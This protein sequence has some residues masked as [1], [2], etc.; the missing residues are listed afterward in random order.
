MQSH[1]FDSSG[2]AVA[3]KAEDYNITGLVNSGM[4]W[5]SGAIPNWATDG[6]D[7]NSVQ[8]LQAALLPR[9]DTRNEPLASQ[10]RTFRTLNEFFSDSGVVMTIIIEATSRSFNYLLTEIAPV[11]KWAGGNQIKIKKLVFHDSI[12]DTV[13]ELGIGD[14][15]TQSYHERTQNTMRIGKAVQMA[16]QTLETEAGRV[17]FMMQ[18]AQV[19]N[20]VNNRAQLEVLINTLAPPVD[21]S[22]WLRCWNAPLD[23]R[24]FKRF[25]DFEHELFGI[26]NRSAEPLLKIDTYAKKISSQNRTNFDTFIV[27]VGFDSWLQWHS[28]WETSYAYT[29]KTSAPDRLRDTPQKFVEDALSRR[30]MKVFPSRHFDLAKGTERIPWDPYIHETVQGDYIPLSIHRCIESSYR[31]RIIPPPD[32][33]SPDSGSSSS[34]GLLLKPHYPSTTVKTSQVDYG[35]LTENELQES[36]EKYIKFS[37]FRE[38]MKRVGPAIEKKP[39]MITR[40][41]KNP[42]R[43]FDRRL[44]SVYTQNHH[45][46]VPCP[47]EYNKALAACGLFAKNANGEYILTPELG[48]SFFSAWASPLDYLQQQEFYNLYQFVEEIE[49]FLDKYFERDNETSSRG[50]DLSNSNMLS[51]S[52][53]PQYPITATTAAN[54][55]RRGVRYTQG[56]LAS[57]GT[58]DT[59]EI[60]R[61]TNDQVSELKERYPHLMHNQLVIDALPLA[62]AYYTIQKAAA[63]VVA[64]VNDANF[65]PSSVNW[66][67][68]ALFSYFD[69][70]L[71]PMSGRQQQLDTV[72]DD[73]GDGDD[74]MNQIFGT[75]VRPSNA[76]SSSPGEEKERERK[77]QQQPNEMDP[78][79]TTE[80]NDIKNCLLSITTAPHFIVPVFIQD[81]KFQKW[82]EEK[83]IPRGLTVKEMR[84]ELKKVV[85]HAEQQMLER[86]E[87]DPRKG[88]G[89]DEEYFKVH[90]DELWKQLRWKHFAALV[91]FLYEFDYPVPINFHY[92]RNVV[93]NAGAI[94]ALKRGA[95]T[96]QSLI[97][98]QNLM[99][100]TNSIRKMMEGNFTCYFGVICKEPRNVWIIPNAYITD[101]LRHGNMEFFVA[102][103]KTRTDYLHNA[104][105]DAIQSKSWFAVPAL[106]KEVDIPRTSIDLTGRY[107]NCVL[108]LL[109]PEMRQQ[110]EH[111]HYYASEIYSRFWRWQPDEYFNPTYL[112]RPNQ[113]FNSLMFLASHYLPAYN[114]QTG[115]IQQLGMPCRGHGAFGEYAPYAGFTADI[116]GRGRKPVS[117]SEQYNVA[118]AMLTREKAHLAAV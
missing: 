110:E 115:Q 33:P 10:E 88:G 28:N 32:A 15:A 49:D 75:E 59:R 31:T 91:F 103:N 19:V 26:C 117:M 36:K 93:W 16:T 89:N 22:D 55:S 13:P 95:E 64:E 105:S 66:I 99:L 4:T 3:R 21:S 77:V 106:H 27:P 76:I 98:W 7:L 50:I 61:V 72:N 84:S 111:S 108:S 113:S 81:D 83:R 102:D 60:A 62:K 34:I 114:N 79:Y 58:Y 29:G 85:H 73:D 53:V 45:L 23:V 40:A 90:Y 6:S 48:E 82:C 118:A 46:D 1:A 68:D 112:M 54:G 43:H 109:T 69:D 18:M 5:S 100:G 70:K 71:E 56:A 2:I 92:F 42:D 25:F 17:H 80:R 38:N 87:D 104:K 63:R 101:Y 41:E 97:G 96:F 78:R 9:I 24:S 107:H 14:I 67:A 37:D 74:I 11:I 35:Y 20:A 30:E 57:L 8:A 65:D 12:A 94:V 52:R 51:G 39:V 86:E 116:T 44:L 47:L